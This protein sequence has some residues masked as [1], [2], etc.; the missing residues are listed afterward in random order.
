MLH[1][2]AVRPLGGARL[3]LRFD[4]GREGVIDLGPELEG[5]VFVPLRDP[6]LF[7]RVM[8]DPETQTI[9]WPNGADFAPEFLAGLLRR[10]PAA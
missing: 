10:H 8:I 5:P 9:A 7:A 3:W 2:T 4:D 1:V 6:A